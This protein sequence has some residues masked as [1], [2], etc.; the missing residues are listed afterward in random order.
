[1]RKIWPAAVLLSALLCTSLAQSEDWVKRIRKTDCA[2]EE[3]KYGHAGGT[4]QVV[5]SNGALASTAVGLMVQL[6]TPWS[7]VT[8][9]PFLGYDGDLSTISPDSRYANRSFGDC[10]HFNPITAYG[11]P[12]F[13]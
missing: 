3:Q 4:P 13:T 5:W 9:V 11:D 7:D 6:L 8:S 10:P 2:I 1:M 12:F